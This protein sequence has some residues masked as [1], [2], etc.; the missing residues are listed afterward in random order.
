MSII[1]VTD[2]DL[3]RARERFAELLANVKTLETDWQYFFSEFPFVFSRSLPLRLEVYDILPRG[4]PGKAEP[5]FIFYP[6]RGSSSLLYGAIE[7]KRPSTPVLT[8]PRKGIID[9]TRDA[10]TAIRQATVYSQNVF[11]QHSSAQECAMFIGNRIHAFVIM[12]QSA[13]IASQLQQTTL[14]GQIDQLLPNGCHLIPYDTLFECFSTSVPP[15]IMLLTP[16]AGYIASD[17]EVVHLNAGISVIA[18]G[19][20]AIGKLGGWFRTS[21]G[22]DCWNL[23]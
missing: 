2:A 15:R 9:L 7:I 12:G 14:P 3:R 6:Q 18:R 16:I 4:R 20:N 21:T 1:Q 5:D 23:K 11:K 17:T 8:L 13:E 22:R 19:S 10:H